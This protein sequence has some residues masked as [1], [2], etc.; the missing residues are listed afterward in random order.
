MHILPTLK[1]KAASP[2]MPATKKK[3]FPHRRNSKDGNGGKRCS[4]GLLRLT[5]FL[6][7]GRDSAHLYPTTHRK[8]KASPQVHIPML[9]NQGS[10]MFPAWG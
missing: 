1:F 9:P 2:K 5:S 6:H 7:E 8:R 4:L 10:P 3:V